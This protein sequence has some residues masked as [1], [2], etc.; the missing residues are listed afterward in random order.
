MD[1]TKYTYSREPYVHPDVFP[2]CLT[3]KN[4]YDQREEAKKT[5]KRVDEIIKELQDKC[6]HEF[7]MYCSGPYDDTYICPKCGKFEEH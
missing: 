2:S 3:V 4:F 6:K 7:F 5:L 1:K